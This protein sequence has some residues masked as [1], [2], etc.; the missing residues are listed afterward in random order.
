MSKP[1]LLLL[2]GALGSKSQMQPLAKTLIYYYH[3]HVIDLPGH[4]ENKSEQPFSIFSFSQVVSDYLNDQKIEN[5]NIFGYS[6]GGYVALHCSLLDARIKKIM[7]LGTKFHW[8]PECAQ[9][10]I[11]QLDPAKIEAKVP[12]FAE[13]LAKR[14]RVNDW[15]KVVSKTADMMIGLGQKPILTFDLL[16]SIKI[17]VQVMLGSLDRMVTIE[18]TKK[19]ASNLKNGSFELLNGIPHPMEK[20]DLALLNPIIHRFFNG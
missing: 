18:E 6:M 8:T 12:K 4:G 3:V 10:E 19:A 5:V 13:M 7:T 1:H 9:H 20:V 15:K 17:P 16:K 14:H 2:H 11:Q